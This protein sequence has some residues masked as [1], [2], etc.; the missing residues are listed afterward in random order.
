MKNFGPMKVLLAVLVVTFCVQEVIMATTTTQQK[1]EANLTCTE[2][3]LH[4]FERVE[5]LPHCYKMLVDLGPMSQDKAVA[6]CGYE[7]GAT[8]VTFDNP[9]DDQTL[10]DHFWTKYENE[11]NTS[12]AYLKASGFWTGFVRFFG[13]KLNPFLNMYTGDP[14]NVNLF[15][16]EQPDDRVLGTKEEEACVSREEYGNKVDFIRGRDAGVT[17]L[18]DY[19]CGFPNWVIC[20]QRNIYM[21]N[22]H[23]WNSALMYGV[24][25][26]KDGTCQLD[27]TDQNYY[28]LTMMKDKRLEKNRPG[29]QELADSYMKILNDGAIKSPSCPQ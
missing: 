6:A 23:A 16:P 14:M 28:Q 1:L 24:K 18:D 25:M 21:L 27:W 8:V 20:M 15:K 29:A 7:G 10:R 5:G 13:N 3:C 17:G 26:P 11:I 4:G 2:Q 12:P 22:M 19:T 9:G